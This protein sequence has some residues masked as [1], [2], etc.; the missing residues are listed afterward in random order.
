MNP[1][2]GARRCLRGRLV[3]AAT[4]ALLFGDIGTARGEDAS[5]WKFRLGSGVLL[6]S[7][8]DTR[9]DADRRLTLNRVAPVVTIDAIRSLD[10]CV[11]VFVSGLV[12][13]IPATISVNDRSIRANRLTPMAV[14][15][16][17]N[18]RWRPEKDLQFFAGPSVGLFIRDRTVGRPPND[19]VAVTVRDA[20]GIGANSGVSRVIRQRSLPGD[21]PTRKR[22]LITRDEW[23]VIDG[24]V[25][26]QHANLVTGDRGRIGW[27]PLVITGG[28][29]IHLW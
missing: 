21:D 14:Q 19:N 25:R 18:Y 10:C 26:W 9:V 28:V 24:S 4:V 13:S 11:E 1:E 27:N 15:V 3:A 20:L 7:G 23:I 16:G 22:R 5:V 8:R 12:P 17:L 2:V 6:S 29:T